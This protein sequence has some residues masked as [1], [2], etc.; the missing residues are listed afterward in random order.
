MDLRLF[1]TALAIVFITLKL[2]GVVT[3]SWWV[4]LL[5]LLPAAIAMVVAFL[6]LIVWVWLTLSLRSSKRGC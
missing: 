1:F 4:V 6:A 2:T 3:W 5:P